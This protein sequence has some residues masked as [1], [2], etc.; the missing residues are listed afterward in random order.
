[1]TNNEALQ[2]HFVGG[3]RRPASIGSVNY[4]WPLIGLYVYPHRFEF[5]PGFKFMRRL[6]RPVKTFSPDEIELVGPTKH[7][8]RFTFRNGERWLFG[9]CNVRAVMNEMVKREVPTT[10]EVVPA[11]WM[12]PL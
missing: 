3:L 12:P 5:G 2:A 1:M 11:R 8:V 6:S 4:S 9:R 10:Q 7:G